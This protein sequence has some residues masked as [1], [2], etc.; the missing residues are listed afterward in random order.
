MCGIAGYAY[1]AG[2]T[3]SP[4]EPSVLRAMTRALTHRGPDAEGYVSADGVAMGHRRLVVIDPLGG[5]QPMRDDR[6]GLSVVFNGEIY[7]YRRLNTELSSLGFAART[8]SDTETVLNAY[9]AWGDQCVDHFNG[10]FAFVIHDRRRRCLFGARDRMGKKPLYYV[11]DRDRFIFASEPRALLEH[12][13]VRR[14]MD[15]EGLARYLVFEHVPAPMTI[16]QGMRKLPHAHRFRFDLDTGR[17]AVERYWDLPIPSPADHERDEAY[18]VD[19]LRVTLDDAVGRRLEADVPLGV[20][21]SGGIDS[22]AVTAA[23]A[24]RVGADSVN[25]FSL[26]FNDPRFDES[27]RAR[28]LAVALGTNHHEHVVGPREVLEALPAVDTLLDEPFADASIIPTWLLARFARRDITVALSGD[29]GDELFAGYQTFRAL[30]AARLYNAV[31]PAA[32]HRRVVTPLADRLPAGNGYFSPDFV[33][34]RFLRGVKVPPHQRLWR[35]L[36]ALAPDE[37]A[38]LVTPELLEQIN[39]GAIFSQL[40]WLD[41]AMLD[42]DPVVRD[43]HLFTRTYL[44]DGVLTKVDRA[45]MACSLEVR[46]PLLDVELVELAASIPGRFKV[47]RGR[48]KHV[49]REAVRGSVPDEVLDRPKQGFALPIGAWFRGPLRELLLDTLDERVIREQGLFRPD[50]VRRLLDEHL[51]GHRDH[52][53]PLFALFMFQRWRHRW[54]EHAETPASRVAA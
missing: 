43:A 32:F 53:K 45:A 48:L 33:A 46:S 14:E 50:A 41:G 23:V 52:R 11:C 54:I 3:A 40:L 21:L 19:R 6:S 8:R 49:F 2:S 15:P 28:R 13:A 7:N 44:A 42:R 27:A 47:T 29:G 34:R 35:W 39:P 24:R 51:A 38:G 25:T 4:P 12:P 22:A 18:W 36:G 37:L 5:A 26:G 31:V 9:A 20:F 10:M 17:F 1:P 16:Y 30:G